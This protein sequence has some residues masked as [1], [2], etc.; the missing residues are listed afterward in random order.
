MLLFMLTTQGLLSQ[1][2][3][4]CLT[5][6][7]F[8]P[9]GASFCSQACVYCALD[10]KM[11]ATNIPL[12]QTGGG[13]GLGDP[14][15]VCKGDIELDNP[16]WYAFV[17][18]TNGIALEIR[19]ISCK[20]GD[21]LQAAILE[22]CGNNIACEPGTA[23]GAGN[24]LFLFSLNMQAGKVY[25]LVVDGFD[26]DECE[27]QIGVVGGEIN[28]PP[29]GAISPIEGE[30]EVCPKGTYTY[31]V[32]LV[33]NA[34]NYTWTAP[35]GASID[36]GGNAKIKTGTNANT[37]TVKYGTAGGSICVTATNFCNP[38]KTICL[39]ITNKI[40]PI[41]QLDT[42]VLCFDDLPYSWDQPP[43]NG[44][45]F[46][47]KYT[48]TSKP[49]TSFRGC[50]SL[51]RQTIIARPRK[52][53]QLPPNW[54][55]EGDCFEINGFLYCDPGSYA[56]R[57]PAADGCDS[58]V[59]FTLIRIN[60]KAVIQKPD[61]LTCEKKSVTLTSKGS[62]RGAI[63]SYFWK[64]SSGQTISTDTVA[65]VSAPGDYSLIVR[66]VGG[67]KFCY[68]TAF[69]KV[70]GVTSVP[71]ANAGPPKFITCDVTQLNLQGSGSSGPGF[72]YQ[73]TASNGG[74]I[75]SGANTLT[76][77]VDS[78]GTYTLVVRNV[79]SGC[80]A[81]SFVDV[82]PNNTPPELSV[83]G[84]AYT[85]EIPFVIL[86]PTSNAVAPTYQWTGPGGFSSTVSNPSVNVSGLYT[87]VVKDSITGCTT[88]ASTNV[89]SD[90]IPPGATAT[91]AV[92]TCT[93]LSDTIFAS[94]SVGTARY[95]W[96]GPGGFNSNL[97]NPTINTIGVYTVTVTIPS[98]GCTSTAT[99][100]VTLD[101]KEPGA[102]LAVSG[103]LNCNNAS[104]TIT[105]GSTAAANLLEHQWV[106]PDATTTNTGAVKTLSADQVGV[107]NILIT[108]TQNG[109]TSTASAEVIKRAAVNAVASG[110]KVKCNG[111]SNGSA[112]AAG[113]GG[114]G[115]F[116][117]KW[118]NDASTAD[119][120]GLTA[121]T[122]TVTITDG[123]NCT[124]SASVTIEQ[125][126]LLN[127]NA[128]STNQVS[129][130]VSDGTATANPSGGTS[131]YTYVW[132]NSG[133]TQTITDL[134]P[135]DYT[136]TVKDANGC[137]SV[138]SVNVK[139]LCA[140]STNQTFSNPLCFGSSTGK[141]TAEPGGGL[142]PINYVWSD[143]QKSQTAV[144]LKSG[145]YTVTLT[146]AVGCTASASVTLV[147]PVV[148]E[149]NI[150][151]S[152]NPTCADKKDGS[153]TAEG[154]GGTGILSYKWSDGQ[155]T[156]TAL[157][158]GNGIT[159]VTVTDANGCT[160]SQTVSLVAVDTD[161]PVITLG[162]GTS[163]TL[164][165]GPDGQVTPTQQ[166]LE[167]QV[168]DNCT[169]SS[170]KIEPAVFDCGTLGARTVTVTATDATGNTTTQVI[171]VTVV[172]DLA[173]LMACPSDIVRCAGGSTIVQYD[174]PTVSDNCI[175]GGT[176]KQTS[177]LPSGATYPQGITT[178]TYTY[179]DASGNTGSC[180]FTVNMLAPI[181][182]K[183]DKVKNDPGNQTGTIDIT[184]N[185]GLPPYKFAWKKN[186][187]DLP[188]GN[189][190]DLTGLGEGIYTVV[191]I[192]ANDCVI[193]SQEVI[194]LLVSANEPKWAEGFSIRPNPTS[195][196]LQVIF[197]QIIDS[198]IVVNMTDASGRLVKSFSFV[199]QKQL[200]LD[201]HELPDG[202]Y[203]MLLQA[204]G[205]QIVRKIV[206]SK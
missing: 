33:D 98:N 56:E 36:G 14:T 128:S 133:T 31:T 21:G 67:G 82:L 104:V 171:D 195:G 186:G 106:K 149:L 107:Y 1:T 105:A 108:N 80:T 192:D 37:I 89:S 119:I 97:Q 167:V 115:K 41:T 43:F 73:W 46:P 40:I 79:A 146:D 139:A 157:Q 11:D 32:P 45:F 5:L 70:I 161:K 110:L 143:G 200:D 162:G 203:N 77:L 180:S 191:V 64:N 92:L 94:A 147:D 83:S 134:A 136:V 101:N 130:G 194:L 42:V 154:A 120:T 142:N 129:P 85:C 27:F 81:S 170:V 193:N 66:S 72:S 153:A 48:F 202:T 140:L 187:I 173:P 25:T 16:R 196:Q 160:A 132:S 38:A 197:G 138:A 47:G 201:L 183:V 100:E 114:D 141:I 68:D 13:G 34:V 181:T 26:G 29:L 12:G 127:A 118:S 199:A 3:Q 7:T 182:V 88:T 78:V 103:P 148:L 206:V 99:T 71:L 90:T 22:G 4:K 69:T 50:D 184:V 166:N 49:F 168:T 30:Q 189:T 190:E 151:A 8:E 116:T 156:A 172:D 178:N 188:G 95:R 204:K 86:K 6:G 152:L 126:D 109:C 58:T 87:V 65:T 2:F 169:V 102:T 137:T 9:L 144:D 135:G 62:T 52:F 113:N 17:P 20:N 131:P 155:T 19:T 18:G 55:C 198:D 159:S 176:F 175:F 75:L 59:S 35:P 61:T 96:A 112:S 60:N 111:E 10:G 150:S 163:I 84:G 54:I 53:K 179:T 76:P 164:K 39:P 158:L 57:M 177:G 185:G 63:A 51:V 28:P 23:G 145:T 44:V 74:R 174:A 15:S 117:F 124:A 93:V 123:E 122:Y 91:G 205:G 24:N 125:P 165:L 121:G